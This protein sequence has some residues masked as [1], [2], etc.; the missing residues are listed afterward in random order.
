MISSMFTAKFVTLARTANITILLSSLPVNWI[1]S[2][3]C[4]VYNG[5]YAGV[6]FCLD[7]IKFSI[8]RTILSSG[9]KTSP[10]FLVSLRLEWAIWYVVQLAV[11]CI[12]LSVF[13]GYTLT[14]NEY[15]IGRSLNRTTNWKFPT[16]CTALV[17]ALRLGSNEIRSLRLWLIWWTDINR[18]DKVR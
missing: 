2:E 16:Y 7:A 6:M 1:P 12:E 15:K 13:F 18:S 10:P 3:S 9:S 14:P 17:A 4:R 5:D 8:Q 11:A